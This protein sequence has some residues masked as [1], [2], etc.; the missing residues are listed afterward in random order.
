MTSRQSAR[1][2]LKRLV[3]LFIS[4]MLVNVLIARLKFNQGYRLG[5]IVN[6]CK[7]NC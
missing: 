7:F 2:E 6:W 4:R 3:G 5:I 1:L